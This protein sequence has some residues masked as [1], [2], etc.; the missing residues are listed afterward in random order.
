[1]RRMQKAASDA[2]TGFR[3]SAVARRFRRTLPPC[4]HPIIALYHKHMR[5]S[6][7]VRHLSQPSEFV[8]RTP[9]LEVGDKIV[10]V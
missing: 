9:R 7:V 2:P 5:A 8:M 4:H 6:P 1:M 3:L 10:Q